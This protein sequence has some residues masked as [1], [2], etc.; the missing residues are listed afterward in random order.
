MTGFDENKAKKVTFIGK[1]SLIGTIANL[2][3]YA[4]SNH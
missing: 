4:L 1:I 2:R 3:I